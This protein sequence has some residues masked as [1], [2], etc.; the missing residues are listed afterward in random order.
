MFREN[1]R[2]TGVNLNSTIFES[3]RDGQSSH[4]I[5]RHPESSL[6]LSIAL[7]R[8]A[9]SVIMS[10]S[11]T[12]SST[13]N[14]NV[15]TQIIPLGPSLRTQYPSFGT[16]IRVISGYPDELFVVDMP[17]DSFRCIVCMDRTNDP[18]MCE[19][20]HT[21]CREC[22][23]TWLRLHHTCPTCKEAVAV[24]SLTR[25]R[26]AADFI[27]QCKVRCLTALQEDG[28][29]PAAKKRKTSKKT[30]PDTCDWVGTIETLDSHMQ[31]CGCISVYC[32]HGD[33]M[34]NCP[35]RGLRS[36]IAEHG[37]ICQFRK[38]AC[39][40]CNTNVQ[41][42]VM[43]VHKTTS[44]N[45]RPVVCLNGCA[46]TYAYEDAAQHV[47][48]CPKQDIVC[49]YSTT[50][51]CSFRCARESMAAHAGDASVHFA[52]LM[53]TLQASQQTVAQLKEQVHTVQE[54]NAEIKR[55]LKRVDGNSYWTQGSLAT[56]KLS[57]TYTS[58][59][60][61]QTIC[62]TKWE[63]QIVTNCGKVFAAH[64]VKCGLKT[65]PFEI[66]YDLSSAGGDGTL[67]PLDVSKTF[68]GTMGEDHTGCADKWMRVVE[69]VSTECLD[70]Y[71]N[72]GYDIFINNTIKFKV[73][74]A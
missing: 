48:V 42:R 55:E 51:G 9:T 28:A 30:D 19:N 41:V 64:F 13:R 12:V 33:A 44:C 43:E 50:L 59:R 71:R 34:N 49:P 26:T 6:S 4:G 7:S 57:P 17:V 37:V 39:S 31:E 35:W 40:Y 1:Y 69:L 27:S 23:T 70:A 3:H 54:E 36:S 18:V 29:A 65:C 62:G 60:E 58:G 46:V 5:L 16:D 73:E 25:N 8:K 72:A 11:I 52:G 53:T 68:T 14:G 66:T 45:R 63:Q 10:G 32:L 2:V 20:Q 21:F 38:E 61:K 74:T 47:A 56:I 67:I 22:L 15:A 24:A